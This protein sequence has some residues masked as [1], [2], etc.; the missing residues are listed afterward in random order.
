MRGVCAFVCVSEEM[1]SQCAHRHHP[2]P[3][4]FGPIAVALVTLAGSRQEKRLANGKCQLL[5]KICRNCPGI[6]GRGK[7][8][9][10][11]AG[12]GGE[13]TK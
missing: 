11:R 8:R 12:T 3:P 5:L 1:R 13:N 4:N 6:K 7:E 2:P 10:G 9:G